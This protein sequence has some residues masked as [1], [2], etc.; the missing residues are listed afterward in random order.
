MPQALLLLVKSP[1]PLYC[2][3][4]SPASFVGGTPTTGISRV[5]LITSTSSPWL[6]SKGEMLE[7]IQRGR[8]ELLFN[9]DGAR[10]ENNS[11]LTIR[12]LFVGD[13]TNKGGVLNKYLFY[14]LSVIIAST[15]SETLIF[16]DNSNAGCPK[17]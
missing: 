12:Q 13:N 11:S 15:L 8:C 1:F 9:L 7:G 17:V 3:A 14:S 5:I 4:S 16:S 2:S 6:P 10:I